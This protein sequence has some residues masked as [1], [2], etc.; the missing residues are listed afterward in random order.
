MSM[1]QCNNNLVAFSDIYD[2]IGILRVIL[3]MVCLAI[4]KHLLQLAVT[5]NTPPQSV[6]EK[7]ES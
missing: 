1:A 2:D 7:T 6:D 3:S 5:R 4:T